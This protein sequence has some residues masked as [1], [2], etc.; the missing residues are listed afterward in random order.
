ML[1]ANITLVPVLA[2][3][4]STQRNWIIAGGVFAVLMLISKFR[5]GSEFRPKDLEPGFGFSSV[6]GCDE[7]VADLREI[8]EFLKNP[9]KFE[10]LGATIPRGALLV[11]PP[12]TGKTLLAR[13]VAA[14]ANVPFISASGSDFVEMFVGVGAK[15]VRELYQSAREHSKAIVFIDELDAVARARAQ[16]NGQPGTPGGPIEHEN[17]LI[18]LLTELDGFSR[19]NVIT[20]A[21]TNRPDVLDPAITRPGR[22][23]RRIEVPRPDKAGRESILKVHVKTKPLAADVELAKVA[24]RTAGFSGADLGRLCNEAALEAARRDLDEITADCFDAA[25]E[26]IAMGRPRTSMVVSERDRKVT[27]WHEAGH[28]ICGWV[29][30]ESP[31]PVAV[32]ITPRGQAAGV[33][34]FETDDALFMSKE[35]AF[36]QLVVA[37]GG[38]VAEEVLMGG[39]CTQGASSDLVRATELATMM[40]TKYG[41]SNS[42]VSRNETYSNGHDEWTRAQVDDLISSAHETA[43]ALLDQHAA[44]LESV[45]SALL[46]HDRLSASEIE[47]ILLTHNT[48]KAPTRRSQKAQPAS[49][50]EP[51]AVPVARRAHRRVKSHRPT[52]HRFEYPQRTSLLGL[53][54][55][56][57]RRRTH[58]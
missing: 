7:A 43:R 18:A 5:N 34:W 48:G 22:L 20:I 45:A 54:G 39:S 19:S 23:E 4:S 40:A 21:A 11:G 53:L 35:Q 30:D 52:Q 9:E 2:E 27:A 15:R 28:A 10:R 25:V 8:V 16:S 56:A 29:L 55:R 46:E 58:G 33:T 26:L 17:T 14:E 32:S 12:G 13:A 36:T 41:M 38:R 51:V 57:F 1:P 3:I 47:R 42:L 50:P 44:A 31:N 6:A 24:S 37:L 49:R